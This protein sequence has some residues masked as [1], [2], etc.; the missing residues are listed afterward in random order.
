MSTNA[1]VI[2]RPQVPPRT[3]KHV[4]I[5]QITTGF[6]QGVLNTGHVYSLSNIDA[7]TEYS[8]RI[9][10][11]VTAR[12]IDLSG[13]L[14]GTDVTLTDSSIV[15]ILIVR[16][17]GF[18]SAAPTLADILQ[19]SSAYGLQE[20]DPA[21]RRNWTIIH[22]QLLSVSSGGP[23]VQVIRHTKDLKQEITYD[24]TT[25]A[26]GN[27]GSLYAMLLSNRSSDTPHVSLHARLWFEDA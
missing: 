8:E 7:G 21:K 10:R 25:G 27:K 16:D 19:D 20:Q 24:G 17:N 1:S 11:K 13:F 9:G 2:S 15:R 22:D 5:K 23:N 26:T 18:G 6:S 4:E 3:A 12:R 14:S